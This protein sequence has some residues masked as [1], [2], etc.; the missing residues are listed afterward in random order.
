MNR[1]SQQLQQAQ[2]EK[3][4]L[5]KRAE[6]E[7]MSN[8][9]RADETI[10][11][12]KSDNLRLDSER[13]S[14]HDH[15]SLLTQ[16]L[17]A[18]KQ[19]MAE[20]DRA[21]TANSVAGSS[22][23][24][25]FDTPALRSPDPD[26]VTLRACSVASVN[27]MEVMFCACCGSQNVV[28]RPSCWKCSTMF[29]SVTA[30][31]G[32]D[33]FVNHETS[34][35]APLFRAPSLA[36][37]GLS[38]IQ[39]VG[40]GSVVPITESACA[41]MPPNFPNTGCLTGLGAAA[42]ATAEQQGMQKHQIVFD[43]NGPRVQAGHVMPPSLFQASQQDGQPIAMHGSVTARGPQFHRMNSSSN[44]Q[45]STDRSES[46][47]AGG[48]RDGA[49]NSGPPPGGWLLPG[50][51]DEQVYKIKHLKGIQIT[52]LPNDATSCREWRAAF[53]AAVSRIDLTDRDVLVKFCVHCMDG[54]RGRRF[55]EDL[56]TSTAF[57]MFNKH[58]AA[59]L[60]KPEVL[61]TNSDLAH[62]LTSWVEECATRREGPKGMPLMNLIISF[63]E[64]GA[65]T[66]VALSQ[67]HLLSLQLAGKSLKD[68][69][70]FVKKTNYILH[71]LK[72]SDRPAESTLYAWLWHQVKRVPMLNRVTERIRN[73]RSGSK[74]RTFDWLWAQIA[75]ELRERRHD[76]N[77]DN[78]SKGLQS[79]P[80]N[81]LALPAQ[82]QEPSGKQHPGKPKVE[83]RASVPA[84]PG[85]IDPGKSSQ[86]KKKIPCALHAAGH[87]RFGTG[88][89][90]LHNGEP[91]SD[92]AKR[93][94]TEYQQSSSSSKNHQKGDG[95]GGSKG[96]KG[97]GK[98]KKGKKGDGK[99]NKATVASTP[100]T[101]AAAAAAS[102]VTITEVDGKKVMEAWKGFCEFCSKALPSM[103][104]FL[105]LSVPILATLISSIVD[106]P[107]FEYMTAA[108]AIHPCVEQFKSMSIE[109]L[110]DT[111]AALDIGSIQA[112]REQGIDPALVKPWISCLDNP[113]R[114]ATG[115]GPQ[116]SHEELKLYAQRVGDLKLHLLEHCPLA[117][118][119]GRQI[120]KGRTFIWRH[121]EAPYIVLNHKKCKIWCPLKHRWYAKRVQ[122]NVPI[123]AIEPQQLEN[124]AVPAV[125][126]SEEIG[127]QDACEKGDVA[128]MAATC[129]QCVGESPPIFCEECMERKYAC[130]CSMLPAEDSGA[131]RVIVASA[132]E[133]EYVTGEKAVV[134]AQEVQQVQ[135]YQEH[136]KKA[137]RKAR[138]RQ[139]WNATSAAGQG[140]PSKVHQAPKKIH[141]VSIDGMVQDL[142]NFLE[143][144]ASK[145]P[146]EAEVYRRIARDVAQEHTV[147]SRS[148]QPCE[149]VTIEQHHESLPGHGMMIEFC[150]SSDSMI[151]QVAKEYGIHV[152]RCTESSLNVEQEGVI[153]S[154]EKIVESKPGCDLWG[155]LPCGPW[156]QWQ[157]MN[158]SRYGTEFSDRLDVQR[159][160]SR[161]MIKKFH[162]LAKVV[163]RNGGRVNFEWPRFCVGWATNEI[164]RMI[165]ELEMMLIDFDG[166]RVGVAD[167]QGHPHLKKWRVATTCGRTARIFSKLRCQHEPEFKH[168][169]IE[170][171]KTT[172]TGRYPK[173]MCEYIMY[174]LYPDIIEKFCPAMP[175][176]AFSEQQV[177]RERE[178]E[179]EPPPV[180]V[181]FQTNDSFA[182]P[183]EIDDDEAPA[184][185][186]DD[187]VRESRDDRLRRDAKSLEHMTLHDR[188]NPFCEHCCRGRMLRR[189]AHRFR[190]EPEDADAAYE[191]PSEFGRIIEADTV[192]PAVES[193]GMGGEHCALVVRDRFSG[194]SIAYPQSSRDEDSNY[195]SLKHFAGYPLSGRTDTIFCSDNAQELT[196]AASRLCWVIDSSA[197]NYWP[198][199]AHLERDVRTIKELSR[200]SHI[201]AGFHKKLWPLTIDYV[202]KARSFFSPAPIANYEKG[203]DSETAKAGKTRWQVATGAEFEGPK[204]PLGALVFYRAKGD[205]L[206]E[207]T[208]KP[209]LFVG[210]HLSAGLR[211]KGNL[212]IIDYEATRT[213]A[214]L[215][216]V[217][218][219]IHQK[220]TFLP[221]IEHV[222]FPLARAARSALLDMTD[223]EMVLK[224]DEFDKS[225]I[226][227]VLPY[228]ICIDAFPIE[229]RAPPP[230]HAYITSQRL[231]RHGLTR[232][233]SG[234][235]NG[236]SRHS[237]ECRARFD[238]I[239]GIR[240]A[241]P[242]TPS[243]V[244]PTPAGEPSSGSGGARPRMED[245]IV[246]E[247]PPR[248]GSDIERD[249]PG[250]ELPAA[251]TRQL[252]R[253]EVLSRPEA[254]EAIRKEMDG[255]A[256]MG[257]WEW[258][259]VEEEQTV[260]KKA[261][262]RG[263]TIHLADLLAICSE[264]HIELEE[265]YRQ[266]KGRVCFRGDAARTESG[267]IALYQ[268]LSASPASIVAANAIICFGL[269]KGCKVSTADAVKA[270]LQSELKSLCETWVRLPR[271]VWPVSWFDEHGN[272]RFYKPVVR[273]RKSLYGHPEAGSHWQEHLEAELLRMG[274]QK[275]PEFPSTFVFPNYGGLALVVYVDDF[276]LAGKEEWHQRFWDDLSKVVQIDDVGDLGRFLG[277]HH[278][279][280]RVEGKE[281]FAFDMRA[282]AQD[283][284]TDYLRISNGK[285]LKVVNTPFFAN[286]DID[287][288]G[289]RGE[290]ANCASSILMKMM[291][292]ARLARPDLLRVTTWLA[293]KIQKWCSGCD[294][295][296]Y[297]AICYI[298]ST[299]S[300]LLTGHINDD[301]DDVFI[302]Y[303]VDA[304]LCGSVDD[305]YS[306]SGAWIQLSGKNTS[307]PLC[308]VS[309]KQTAVSRSTTES[310]TVALA[311]ILFLE[312]IPLAELFSTLLERDVL[313]RIRED[314]EA[315]AKVCTA[316]YSKKLRHLKRVHKINLASVKD[317]L[318]REDTEL[319]LVGTKRQKADIFTK[320]L[321]GPLWPNA[322]HMLGI[323][324]TYEILKSSAAGLKIGENISN[325]PNM[326]LAPPG[327]NQAHLP[328]YRKRQ[329]RKPVR[330]PR[331]MSPTE[332]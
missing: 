169:V 141:G 21:S 67:M 183:A 47:P 72:P 294:V 262:D 23:R 234:C 309:K 111:G 237:A 119:I 281:L 245:D 114:F 316:G 273:L 143:E 38:Q 251:V 314:N 108:S 76:S 165:K 121:G 163:I 52:R 177:H 214:H 60:I 94:F 198:H 307:F 28:G 98:T 137:N 109:L 68:V 19:Q 304:D 171:S 324:D 154:L 326:T 296:L 112:L 265:S 249:D 188:K 299:K 182:C 73:S 266:L 127:C 319:M 92:V 101:A 156:S 53:L 8:M 15:I 233:C 117:M 270:Y 7:I 27:P 32:A 75:E 91:G 320:S 268:T 196:N 43:P 279:T 118:S 301:S 64:T 272:P 224:R 81:Q 216:W 197:P 275:I 288:D 29:S 194:V 61:A 128:N 63:Y 200:P 254:L 321:A 126:D 256:S 74:K 209:G 55:R 69:G 44:S 3:A 317:Q 62:E 140:G 240:G 327:R 184:D 89:R 185:D 325:D 219:V 10:S 12:L 274:G 239:Y 232:G 161:L 20:R 110:G 215:H 17:A 14:M 164:K 115:G 2:H 236:H 213:R 123:F 195:E 40:T 192:F 193:R 284:V 291:W 25:P 30:N 46:L 223:V 290:L 131:D 107:N 243:A 149:N 1:D 246:P 277:R 203:T 138:R 85:P 181:L 323:F 226:K 248:S 168:S 225:L 315:C 133:R 148:E 280:V 263:E 261:L 178:P 255:V 218:K 298:D 295:A 300:S 311:D 96:S 292:L 204:Y 241:A 31:N 264:K 144:K 120:K 310:E 124:E 260:K 24:N 11:Q 205:G 250:D 33:Q 59:E 145:Q 227:G 48:G 190:P 293:T 66:S 331:Y 235:D 187:R 283:I 276:V 99:S 189:Y 329:K 285:K 34:S 302:E 39:R 56:Q 175:V 308:W 267:N 41:G 78:V 242:P 176:M 253:S 212:L 113:V 16:E 18:L 136:L 162:R 257:T 210:W 151:G 90:N 158:T 13:R 58:V 6:G 191:R 70:E 42:N 159:M 211:F 57:S 305:C 157:T 146:T 88:C 132:L 93:A 77:F 166:C 269:L 259:S 50:E 95:K 278:S 152:V 174:A 86:E 252:P 228:D 173:V 26:Q 134:V 36:H 84:A 135:P 9:Q 37:S 49:G 160:R 222:E 201:Q 297:R 322:L 220:E 103:S 206:A 54:G 330:V 97:D 199:N 328:G 130:V 22:H 122:N 231:T 287:S 139:R 271:E 202:S 5:A 180:H 116:T 35:V 247:C 221:P 142:T 207:P 306:T 238:E 65:D 286:G 229:D 104:V 102:T 125:A 147:F 82:H 45:G 129:N 150:T 244:P 155:S 289:E 79:S 313:L 303:F 167:S 282:Y 100:T 80:P 217:P 172:A 258:D 332:E 230:G 83:S 170:G 106:S 105:K 179:E 208:T 153:K 4:I 186:E 87:C 71:G 312:A 318:D 51:S